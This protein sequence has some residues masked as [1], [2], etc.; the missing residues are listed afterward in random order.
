MSRS[1]SNF[2]S[3]HS[4]SFSGDSEPPPFYSNLHYQEVLT[5]LRYGIIARKG[6]VLLIGGAG[7]GKT[8]LLRQFSREL[9]SNVTC[10]F[11]SD[12]DV[13]FTDLLR[14]ILGNLEVVGNTRNELSMIQ[15]CKTILRAE[16]ERG[17]I[18]SLVIDNAQ[19]LRDETLE[20]LLHNFFAATPADRDENLLQIV[21]AG[22]SELRERLDQPRLRALKPRSDLLCQLQPL[23]DNDITAYIENRLRTA[24]LPAQVFD[25]VAINQIAGYTGGNPQLVNVL[26]DRTLQIT[27]GSPVSKV[28]P[29]TIARAARD[30]GLSEPQHP[31]RKTATPEPN[32]EMPNEREESFRFQPT[33]SD[34]TEVVGQTFLNYTSE[35]RRRWLWPVD[36]N[37][38]VVRILV[39]L[40]LFG[41]A[42]AW[43]QSEVGK[44]QLALW[45][46]KQNGAVGAPPRLGSDA[47][48]PLVEEQNPLPA[49]APSSEN[50][51]TRP[52][53]DD[54]SETS[55]PAT[56]KPVEP[57]SSALTEKAPVLTEKAAEKSPAEK[58]PTSDPKPAPKK[59]PMS[60]DNSRQAPVAENADAQRKLLEAHVY[61]ALENRAIMGVDVSVINGTAYL[62]GRVATERQRDAAE[63][64]A[65]SVAGVQR[66]RNRIAVPVS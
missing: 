64:A 58:P 27:E 1:N 41:G 43:L 4:T 47:D 7:T 55:L 44:N 2:E 32:F 51:L 17:H 24:Q 62:E 38:T 23:R 28:S 3:Q 49:P 21:L 8:T 66:V 53:I 39:I 16:L 18:V 34:T 42:A 12:P 50:P 36:R 45:V 10:I 6:L 35:E 40:L 65:R 48:A 29:E 59:A 52:N 63:R 37:R 46:G 20:Y 61:K 56:E 60:A 54:S 19:R 5:T 57:P 30:L 33:E 26:C 31:S 13:N 14:L 15:R 22:R 25:R 11:E 9:D